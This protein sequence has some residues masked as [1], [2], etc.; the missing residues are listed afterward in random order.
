[1][2]LLDKY[3]ALNGEKRAKFIETVKQRGA[4]FGIYPLANNQYGMWSVY[5]TDLNK[6]NP[7][8]NASFR[9]D[10]RENVDNENIKRAINQLFEHQDI[11]SFKFIEIEGTP[12][13]YFDK[14]SIPVIEEVDFSLIEEEDIDTILRETQSKFCLENFNLFKENPIRFQLIKAN[15]NHTILLIAVHHI[16]SD[17]WSDGLIC[18]FIIDG[19]AN[20]KLDKNSFQYANY[21]VHEKSE[22]MQEK[23][24]NNLAYWKETLASS[25]S[26][27]DLPTVYSRS[28]DK[29]KRSAIATFPLDSITTSSINNI[30]KETKGNLHT[31]LLSFFS[32]VLSRY[33]NKTSMNIGTT[34][35]NRDDLRYVNLV[36]DFASVVVM[37]IVCKEQ[38]TVLELMELTK[39]TMLESMDHSGVIL[40]DIIESV[41]FQRIE[42]VHPL[43]Q[44]IFAVHSKKLF[45]GF[46]EGETLLIN[47]TNIAMQT[48]GSDNTNDYKLDLCVV[49]LDNGENLEFQFEYSTKLFSK[50]RIASLAESFIHIL[51]ESVRDTKQLVASCSLADVNK[52]RKQLDTLTIQYV[53]KSLLESAEIDE[54]NVAVINNEMVLL[55]S[56]NHSVPLGFEGD[57]YFKEEEQWYY[58]GEKGLID[59]H[60][61]FQVI[62]HKSRVISM[63]G[64]ILDLLGLEDAVSSKFALE[65]C[66]LKCDED[67]N[68]IL[69]YTGPQILYIEDLLE[70]LPVAPDIIYRTNDIFSSKTT[71]TIKH[72]LSSVRQL[73]EISEVKQIAILQQPQREI[74][75]IVFSTKD[76]KRLDTVMINSLA[77]N[78]GNDNVAFVY[79]EE[80]PV[81]GGMINT[82]KI[83]IEQL[84]T[85]PKVKR[86]NT[87]E[88][89][90][91]I[92]RNVLGEDKVFGFDDKFLEVGGSSIKIIQMMNMINKEFNMT[93]NIAELFDCNTISEISEHLDKEYLFVTKEK[94]MMESY[95]F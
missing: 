34:L 69:F 51:R 62:K 94:S 13:Q 2:N 10:F 67:N 18:K 68:L 5:R 75:N 33:A 36:G 78:K 60:G 37:P 73:R 49:T 23:L 38:L 43:Y 88:R 65:Y 70:V 77:K 79:C 24:K 59:E 29:E 7:F 3:N 30:V 61:H 64:T 41:S 48:L 8:Y 40:S 50:A 92:W 66:K 63:N 71:N 28:S 35:A 56:S 80:F 44:I 72:I 86:S 15:N 45:S 76:K 32:I 74:F 83:A 14:D 22:R 58:T 27:L 53:P 39:D 42:N 1:M 17:G 25:E 54:E 4:E 31:V 9:I 81:K 57:I 91:A 84:F 87:E 26:F 11:F 20:R 52:L 46:A 55:D 19:Y 16:I 90:A 95:K 89:V 47:G 12:Y 93:I 85:Y 82:K 21:V 6:E